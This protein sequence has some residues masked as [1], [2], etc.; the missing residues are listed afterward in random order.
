MDYINIPTLRL[1]FQTGSSPDSQIPFNVQI[2]PDGLVEGVE[3]VN[4]M[5]NSPS[6]FAMVN[7]DSAVINIIDDDGK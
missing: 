7:P 6:N 2:L 3:T 4:L 5:A 1:T